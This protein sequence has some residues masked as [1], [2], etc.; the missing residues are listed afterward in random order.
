MIVT[1]TVVS[2]PLASVTVKVWSPAAKPVWAGV[3]VYPAVPPAGVITTEPLLPP[4][5]ETFTWDPAVADKSFVG[6]VIITD[7]VV[8]HPL[9]SLT[10]IE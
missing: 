10:I 1:S 4:L 3:I 7:L 9:A 5:Q 2:H 6:C 8:I